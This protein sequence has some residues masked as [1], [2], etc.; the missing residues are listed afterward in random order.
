MTPLR[1][2]AAA[3]GDAALEALASK[4]LV[5]RAAADEAS[6]KVAIVSETTTS[7]ELTADGETVRIDAAGPERSG[8]TCPAAGL[9]RHRL[10]ALIHLRGA[11]IE[12]PAVATE[13]APAETDWAAALVRITADD[14][15]AFAGR[16]AA[17]EA[18]AAADRAVAALEPRGGDLTVRLAAQDPVLFRAAGGLDTAVTKAPAQR[19]KAA[20]ATA[21][22]AAR[23]ALGLPALA[24][25]AELD[26]GAPAALDLTGLEDVRAFLRR[27]YAVGL[28]F[29][30]A[31]LEREAMRLALA[32]RVET[33]P[34]LSALLRRLAS[35]LAALRRRDADADSD[36]LLA[37]AA[38][39][40]ALTIA[41]EAA[42][43]EQ[44]RLALAGAPRQEYAPVGTLEL[45]GLGAQQWEA[46]SGAHGVTAHFFA[47]PGGRAY[48]ASLARG[49]RLDPTFHPGEA[50]HTTPLWGLPLARTC[51]AQLTL[52][53]ALAS[54]SGRLSSSASTT[55]RARSWAPDRKAVRGW[56]IAFED[57]AAL[58]THLQT[59][60]S[61]RLSTA[62]GAQSPVVLLA[63][64]HAQARFDELTQTLTW[65]V[66]DAQG[67]W[68]G[69][70]LQFE[71][72]E[73][74]RISVLERLI[75]RERFWGVVCLAEEDAGRIALSPFAL[76]GGKA[77]LLDGEMRRPDQSLAE[78]RGT[79]LGRLRQAALGTGGPERLAAG[80]GP[81]DTLIADA[82][83]VL[84]KRAE[85]GRAGD[86]EAL[87]RSAADAAGRLEAGGLAALAGPF[88]SLAA[89]AP[90]DAAGQALKCAYALATARRARARLLWMG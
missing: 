5:R 55:A 26:P 67:R 33:L 63:A 19:R 35:G 53:G 90:G 84:L 74:Q 10:A 72:P 12:E 58:E 59:A 68:I 65:P 48:S 27:L 20:I 15:V 54:P 49:N 78:E 41:L 81:T 47:P 43:D 46:A 4:G 40:Y 56:P 85:L 51:Q 52:T 57:W 66:R 17:K 77:W 75:A 82:W 86:D 14:V 30:P 39:T 16:T 42:P 2:M 6:G 23:Q 9:C 87:A 61:P 32:G 29:T 44:A 69:L 70:T 37:I 11:T 79:L 7:A 83:A 45:I 36:D 18:F 31:A 13:A 38:E 62:P 24:P 71:G 3:L 80:A 28:A 1:R 22:L 88:K 25:P 73:R 21:Y 64:T 8:C 34:R 76:W 60:L 50:F 89:A